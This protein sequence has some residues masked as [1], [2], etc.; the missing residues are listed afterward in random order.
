MNCE[1]FNNL[2]AASQSEEI[3]EVT[4]HYLSCINLHELN[5]LSF[6]S[7]MYILTVI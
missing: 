6:M 3:V 7:P 1:L 4:V 2:T 5:V